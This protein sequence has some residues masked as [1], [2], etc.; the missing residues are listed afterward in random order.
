M[1]RRKRSWRSVGGRYVHRG[2][3][4]KR[5]LRRSGAQ[6]HIRFECQAREERPC[7]VEQ[8]LTRSRMS[9]PPGGHFLF[10]LSGIFGPHGRHFLAKFPKGNRTESGGTVQDQRSRLRKVAL[11]SET[12]AKYGVGL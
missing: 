3:E 11:M 9:D 8:W 4:G 1:I 2:C 10:R 5:R 7:Y 6:R 12:T